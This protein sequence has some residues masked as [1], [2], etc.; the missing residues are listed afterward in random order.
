MSSIQR[1]S[2]KKLVGAGGGK[3]DSPI[4]GASGRDGWGS[5][6][7]ELPEKEVLAGKIGQRVARKVQLNRP[8]AHT[9]AKAVS[10]QTD[11]VRW[12]RC[13]DA[14]QAS[15]NPQS[16]IAWI[17]PLSC[18]P[19]HPFLQYKRGDRRANPSSAG[20]SA[21]LLFPVGP[22]AVGEGRGVESSAG[23]VYS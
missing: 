10:F 20:D 16:L 18:F 8:K 7:S 3:A 15:S 5:D 2:W 22:G 1:S 21:T 13:R 4:L 12:A 9:R 23:S 6:A 11:T 17:Q 19:S 14:P